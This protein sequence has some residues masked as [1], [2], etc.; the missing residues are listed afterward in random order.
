MDRHGTRGV[1]L[2]PV[3][4]DAVRG[5]G[6]REQSRPWLAAGLARRRDHLSFAVR[7]D[8]CRVAD[9]LAFGTDE[10]GGGDHRESVRI[11]AETRASLRLPE[12]L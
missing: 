5:E 11:V 12:N 10:N 4:K 7:P 1:P 8:A 3:G 9:G 2:L 6:Q